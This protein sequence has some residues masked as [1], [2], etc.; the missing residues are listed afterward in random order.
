MFV[1]ENKNHSGKKGNCFEKCLQGFF[2]YYALDAES[3]FLSF[4]SPVILFLIWF[5]LR[6]MPFYCG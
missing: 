3:P 2:F 6:L 1:S 4:P 5:I